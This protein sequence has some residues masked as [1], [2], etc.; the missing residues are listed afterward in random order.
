MDRGRKLNILYSA[1]LDTMGLDRER[2]RPT[3]GPF[4]GVVPAR[5]ATPLGQIDLPGTTDIKRVRHITTSRKKLASKRHESLPVDAQRDGRQVRAAIQLLQE[6]H[7][8]SS[9]GFSA[10]KCTI[11]ITVWSIVQY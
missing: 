10:N 6:H 5:Q 11:S 1:M 3:G 7:H 8:N 2:L 9:S 4:H